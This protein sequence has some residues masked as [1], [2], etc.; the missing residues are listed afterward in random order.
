M[1]R[2]LFPIAALLAA[3]LAPAQE[4]G[5]SAVPKNATLIYVGSRT[6]AKGQGISVFRLQS[7]GS[8]V[9][10]NVTLVPLGLAAETPNPVYIETDP[11]R[12]LLFAANEVDEGTVSAFS[13]GADGKLT[14][15]NKRSSMGARPC[16][17]ALD[18]DGRHVAVANCGSGSLA[19]LPV[20]EDG[21]LG[22]VSSVVD[23]AGR[24]VTL[25]PAG[26]F[27]F[28]C[29]PEAAQVRVYRFE[30]GKLSSAGGAVA[31]KSGARPRELV[32]RP[33][34][35]FAY[36][37]DEKNSAIVSYGY[38]A[39]SGKLTEIESVS[40]L[41]EWYDGPNEAG[42]LG[43]HRSGKYLYVSNRGHNSVVLFAVDQESGRAAFVEE[44]G[45]G[46]KN[47]RHFGI[48]PIGKHMAIANEDSDTVLGARLDDTN[49]RLKPSGIFAEVPAP[50]FVK[51]LPPIEG[52]K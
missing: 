48:E 32:F 4:G 45:T 10:Q 34:G 8:E 36:V 20:G 6:E 41:P 47:P 14:L 44:Q 19:V 3:T 33:D 37:V 16:Q 51:F 11:K 12:R 46:G 30:A 50:V 31:L 42:A 24:G 7:A 43:T 13:I 38:D 22:E 39:A 49:G 26:A 21:R 2:N 40:T 17:L 29:D 9:F 1:R 52:G 25:D 23:N 15:L 28:A 35:K 27:A 5:S 18:G